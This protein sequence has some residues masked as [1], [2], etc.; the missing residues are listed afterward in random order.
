MNV[1]ASYWFD[2]DSRF[3]G[4]DRPIDPAC[5]CYDAAMLKKLRK[6]IRAQANPTKA[7]I[8]QGFFKTGKG[9]YAEGD[10]FLGLTVPISRSIAKRNPSLSLADLTTLLKSPI[11]EERLVALVLLVD[12]YKKSNDKMRQQIFNLYVKHTRYINNWDLV[13]LSAGYIVG[14][15]ATKKELVRLATS[16]LLWDRRIAMIACF[17][18]IMQGDCRNALHIARL[19]MHDEHD[20]IH[21][22]VGWMLRE[23]GKRCSEKTLRDFLDKHAHEMPRTMLRYAIERLPKREQKRYLGR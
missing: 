5:L 7:K 20:L 15:T 14:P 11:H 2:L 12:R 19:L 3:H 8:L 23:V 22:A 17:H 1:M 13:D 10:R 9:D 16:P 6:D 21:K 18:G 4:N